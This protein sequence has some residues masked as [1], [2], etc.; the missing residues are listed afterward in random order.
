[1]ERFVDEAVVLGSLDYGEA[2]KLVTLFTKSRGRLSAFANGARK[3]KRRFAGALEPGTRL[4][5]QLVERR[6]DTLRLDGVEVL[7]THHHLRDDLP[8][9]ARALYALELIR[10]L[11]RDQQAHE[12]LF[13]ALV[14]YLAALDEKC[15]GPSSLLK[16]EL[17]A[18]D[19]TGLR[20]H[21]TPCA[22]CQGP[23]GHRPRFDSQ[24]GG[25]L[26]QSCALVAPG[27]FALS[28]ELVEA[29][30]GLQQGS[31]APLSAPMRAQAR[32]LLNAFISH[33]LGRKLRSVDFMEQVGTD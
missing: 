16:F 30:V 17:D 2:D 12:G 13:D 8:L 4:N 14:N 24:H 15:A 11:T 29:L 28:A 18:L 25:V 9:I 31:R 22:R 21:F 19:E 33:H 3:S 7:R 27:A 23:T 20:P 10:E 6:G 32:R 5:A 1:M 26:C